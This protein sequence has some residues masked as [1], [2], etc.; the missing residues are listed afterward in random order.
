MNRTRRVGRSA[1][2]LLLLP[3]VVPFLP[4]T[5]MAEPVHYTWTPPTTGAA[6][7][8]YHVT[9]ASPWRT[10]IETMVVTTPTITCDTGDQ[11]HRIFVAGE[12]ALGRIGVDSPV[13]DPWIPQCWMDAFWAIGEQVR[14][15]PLSLV[16]AWVQAIL[17]AWGTP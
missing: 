7:V 15:A 14:V 16:V 3:M 13:S 8:R 11:I 10:V 17:G 9:V 6:V 5:L 4:A 2:R 12:D 1:R